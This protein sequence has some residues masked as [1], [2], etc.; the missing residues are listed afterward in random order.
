MN[1]S[2]KFIL[3]Q[4]FSD[5]T[6]LEKVKASSSACFLNLSFH[7]LLFIKV[8]T[9]ISDTNGW[10]Y[11][12]FTIQNDALANHILKRLCIHPNTLRRR[13]CRSVSIYSPSTRN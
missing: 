3:N 12:V 13:Y 9:N 4:M 5:R 1:Y 7:P 8:A 10:I 2:F 6:H 11:F